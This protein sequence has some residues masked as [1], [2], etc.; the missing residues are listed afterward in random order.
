MRKLLAVL[1]LIFSSLLYA[2]G[3]L[4]FP[5]GSM[6]VFK[7]QVSCTNPAVTALIKDELVP[8]FKEARARWWSRPARCTPVVGPRIP[9][10][11]TTSMS[12]S[13]TAKRASS[14]GA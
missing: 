2:D 4:R 3:V 9:I 11:W 7:T 14:L 13:K 6:I 5:N 1:L 8:L 12:C 10:L